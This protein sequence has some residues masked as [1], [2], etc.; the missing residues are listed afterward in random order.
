M[1]T[2]A[3]EQAEHAT[4]AAHDLTADE[5]ELVEGTGNRASDDAAPDVD[6][7]ARAAITSVER[8]FG[9][10]DSGVQSAGNPYASGVF[11]SE[12]S[13]ARLHVA[14]LCPSLSMSFSVHVSKRT[15]RLA[16]VSHLCLEAGA[17]ATQQKHID[18]R[19]DF[20]YRSSIVLQGVFLGSPHLMLLRNPRRALML[21]GLKR[22]LWLMQAA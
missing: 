5:D 16:R 15:H 3:G 9:R 1:V 8:T 7:A 2:V 4:H 22:L 14:W 11:T 20:L 6:Q 10:L 17:I 21:R 13:Q 12:T 18:L 19:R